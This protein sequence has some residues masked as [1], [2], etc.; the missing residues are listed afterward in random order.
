MMVIT[1]PK[2]SVLVLAAIPLIVFPLILSGRGVRRRSRAAQDRLADASAYAAEAVGAI[3]TMQAFGMGRATAA[4]LRAGVGERLCG[5]PRFDPGAGAAHRRRDLPDLGQR[6]RRAVVRRARRARRHHDG[7][8]ALA[9]R[10]LRGVR[11]ERARPAL[12]GLRRARPGGRRR[13][14]P[15]RDPGRRTGDPGPGRPRA[16]AGARRGATLAFEAVRFPY[17]TRPDTPSLDGVSFPIAPRRAGRPRRPLGRRQDHGASAAPAL[18]RSAGS[19]SVRVDGRRHRAGRSRGLCASASRSCRRSPTIFS[20]T[21]AENIR[22]GRPDATEAR[23]PPRRRARP[24]ERLHPGPA[25]GLRHRCRRARRHAVGRP[26]PAHR[27]RARH[28]EGRA[29][30]APR[31]GDLGARRR[32]RAGGAGRAR[33][34]D[35][36]THHARHRPPPRDDPQRRPHPRPR[37]RPDRRGGHPRQPAGASRGL[38]A[39]LAALQFTDA[40]EEERRPAAE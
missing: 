9:V 30:P 39:Q 26:A 1:S 36:G 5:G 19:G 13:R 3:R 15:R 31:R 37:R 22:Y 21:V 2:L 14:A 35:A 11:R 29:D 23:G 12:G 27:D 4:P 28:P 33:P 32:E 24:C 10:A 17:P 20:G 34:P 40:R 6:R 16:A 18:L 38:Y 7:G 8:P 25:A